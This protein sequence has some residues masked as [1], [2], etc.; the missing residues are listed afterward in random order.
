M[1]QLKINYNKG[2][3]KWVIKRRLKFENKNC[4]ESTQIEN[5][6]NNL[7]KNQINIGSI[8]NKIYLSSNENKIMIG[9]SKSGKIYLLFY[10]ISQPPDIDKIYLHSTHPCKAKYLFFN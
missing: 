6:A 9:G 2:T 8:I 3:K 4:L 1:D 10:R 7:E 5:K